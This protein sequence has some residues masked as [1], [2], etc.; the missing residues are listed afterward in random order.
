MWGEI[1][2]WLEILKYAYEKAARNSGLK[3]VKTTKLTDV[4]VKYE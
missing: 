3:T 1:D 2:I 4:S